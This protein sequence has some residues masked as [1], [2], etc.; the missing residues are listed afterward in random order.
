MKIYYAL[1]YHRPLLKYV[2]LALFLI[3]IFAVSAHTQEL[4][5]SPEMMDVERASSVSDLVKI[6]SNA[7]T[8][9]KA[10]RGS[11]P[12]GGGKIVLHFVRFEQMLVDRCR[13][14]Q[15]GK[16][17]S[18]SAMLFDLEKC[19]YHFELLETRLRKTLERDRPP[20]TDPATVAAL[21]FE[22]GLL[23]EK[24]YAPNR[25][26]SDPDFFVR[27]RAMAR[28]EF[29]SAL[30][31]VRGVV[32]RHD[33]FVTALTFRLAQAHYENA[34]FEEALALIE[35]NIDSIEKEFGANSEYLLG[36][37]FLY[38]NILA[39]VGDAR[40]VENITQRLK[41]D[42]G[43]E[44]EISAALLTG[45]ATSKKFPGLL[46]KSGSLVVGISPEFRDY[47]PSK[48]SDG[49]V[50]LVTGRLAT[51]VPILIVVDE[52]G[53]VT[54]ATVPEGYSNAEKE[55]LKHIKKWTFR[56]LNYKGSRVKMSGFVFFWVTR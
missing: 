6:H 53:N 7:A 47:S 13:D 31:L 43:S 37:L 33:P 46:E 3:P 8:R 9:S 11:N 34:N 4:I 21:K 39:I 28:E 40:A 5:F 41:L 22:Y 20:G 42:H 27:R 24:T 48:P 26:Y 44:E 52:Q 54:E 14:L 12:L 49:G 29:S 56:P 19:Q 23:L 51:G 50:A 18:Q 16:G 15:R 10:L 1:K 55:I 35:T 38:R 25:P 32:P 2:T 45:R 36:S 17:H 30:E